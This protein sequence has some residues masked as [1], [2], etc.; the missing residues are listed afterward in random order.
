MKGRKVKV[1]LPQR[2]KYQLLVDG[3]PKKISTGRTM[4]FDVPDGNHTV[5]IQ[6]LESLE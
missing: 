5:L 3:A 1:A 6:L 4:T 2:G